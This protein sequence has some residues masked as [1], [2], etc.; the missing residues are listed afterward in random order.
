MHFAISW[1]SSNLFKSTSPSCIVSVPSPM[2]E[3]WG[4]RVNI[5]D[6]SSFDGTYIW[7]EGK[8]SIKITQA[9]NW[10]LGDKFMLS[11][12]TR[13]AAIAKVTAWQAISRL[14]LMCSSQMEDDRA[15][16]TTD[17]KESRDGSTVRGGSGEVF[18]SI[19][20]P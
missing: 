2:L 18:S 9:A 1:Q 12:R 14:Y 13:G 10:H 5:C 7:C 6:S 8:V 16:R 3:C 15:C 19:I 17:N 11:R 4:S 20:F